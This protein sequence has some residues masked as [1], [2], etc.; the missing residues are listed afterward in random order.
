MLA[1]GLLP[2]YPL[3]LSGA[4]LTCPASEVLL[5]RAWH[6]TASPSLGTEWLKQVPG[7]ARAQEGQSHLEGGGFLHLRAFW[8]PPAALTHCR[9]QRAGPGQG[10]GLPGSGPLLPLQSGCR[11]RPLLP[12][13]LAGSPASEET[14]VGPQLTEHPQV[15]VRKAPGTLVGGHRRD[16]KSPRGHQLRDRK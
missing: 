13:G 12:L 16:R 6:A 14:S 5:R 4:P 3:A 15:N 9:R 11:G 7:R 8:H 1:A 10:G 2:T